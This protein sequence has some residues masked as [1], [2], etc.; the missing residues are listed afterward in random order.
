[1][2]SYDAGGRP[3]EKNF[4]S[5]ATTRYTWNADNTLANVTNLFSTT[6]ISQHDYTYDAVSNRVT[7]QELVNGTTTP[8]KHVYDTLSRL[9]E[10]RNNTTNAL[11]ES[12]GYDVLNNRTSKTDSGGIVTVYVHD[13]ANQLTEI[14]QT[15][16]TGTLLGGLV[17]DANGSLTRK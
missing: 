13:P 10:V 9:I 5:G 17:Y 7:H 8:Y 3:V 15:T 11:I 16:Q 6:T 4:P 14:R 1:S 2:F 12:Y